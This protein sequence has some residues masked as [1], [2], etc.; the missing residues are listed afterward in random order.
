MCVC[1]YVPVCTGT[2]WH[3]C[4]SVDNLWELFPSAMCVLGIGIRFSGFSSRCLS[5]LR[6]LIIY[7]NVYDVRSKSSQYNLV[8]ILCNLLSE[9][10][11]ILKILGLVPPLPATF[12]VLG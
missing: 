10:F 12:I 8:C 1:I 9:L 4:R 3:A 11:S 2:P 5:P 7:G 6:S